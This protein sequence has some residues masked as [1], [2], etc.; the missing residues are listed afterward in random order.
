MNVDTSFGAEPPEVF[1]GNRVVLPAMN[2]VGDSFVK[3]L[4]TNLELQCARRKS[5]DNLAECRR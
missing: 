3:G 5:L 1:F 2:V 4:D